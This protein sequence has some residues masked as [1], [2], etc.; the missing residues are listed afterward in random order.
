MQEYTYS[1]GEYIAW[2]H[3]AINDYDDKLDTELAERLE[4]HDNDCKCDLCNFYYGFTLH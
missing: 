4:H 3:A 2:S 1:T